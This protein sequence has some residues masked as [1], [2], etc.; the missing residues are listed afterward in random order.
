MKQVIAFVSLFLFVHSILKAQVYLKPAVGINFID[1]SKDPINGHY[2]SRVGYQGGLS[3]LI[4]RT[5]FIEPGAFY[6]R[7]SDYITITDTTSRTHVKYDTSGFRFPL[8]I[9]VELWDKDRHTIGFRFYGG[10]SIFFPANVKNKNRND[11][12]TSL[13]A[14]VGIDIS[15]L[16]IDAQYEWL[17]TN[18]QS[19]LSEIN[20]G[21]KRSFFI[22]A[23]IRIRL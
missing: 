2:T 6:I 19:D 4:G 17:V 11:Y 13:F 8:A 20:V 16:F 10:P 21:E 5:V 23:G 1:F 3:L 18:V 22:N 12:K 15:F 7:E 9:G 14:G